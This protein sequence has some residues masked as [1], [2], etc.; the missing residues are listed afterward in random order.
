MD[1]SQRSPLLAGIK[2][3]LICDA[4]DV[5]SGIVDYVISRHR[6]LGLLTRG[7]ERTSGTW[8]ATAIIIVNGARCFVG[9]YPAGRGEAV[10]AARR[11]NERR[12]VDDLKRMLP[13]REWTDLVFRWRPAAMASAIA[14]LSRTA[15]ADGRRT[16][17]LARRLRRRY[18]VFRAMRVVELIAYYRRYSQLFA[19]RRFELAVMSS[20]SNPHGIALNLA[21]R[22]FGVPVVLITHGM[23]IRPIARLDY[24][25]A[26]M[27]CEASRRVYED[28]GCRMDRTVIKSRRREY[29]PLRPPSGDAM[30]IGVFLS[31][32]PEE[33]QVT[34]TVRALLADAR[35]RQVLV[36]PHPVNL[37]R[38]LSDCIASFRDPRVRL[39]S[40]GSLDDDVRQCDVV[41]AGNSTVHVDA[42]VAG[43]PS[44]YVRG[45]D[46]GPYDVQSFVCN[47]LV[48]EPAHISPIDYS[49]VRRFYTRDEWPR[50]LRRYADVDHDSDEV[51]SAVRAAVNAVMRAT[52]KNTATE[53]TQ[54]DTEGSHCDRAFL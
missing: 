7:M 48:I 38:R 41:L 16:A 28:A 1:A 12:A 42:L 19:S 5:V 53:R 8:L 29:E 3:L 51:A 32:D 4:G 25:V 27:E 14:D 35:V 2:G 31:K 30:T 13:G 15:V 9:V 17:A 26:I 49:A 39:L 54:R 52:G 23:P 18:G 21:A 44:C 22:R 36:R 43:R 20:H 6:G 46:H 40:A 24:T 50:I 34:A 10:V 33:R 37:W 45:F 47:G 11:P